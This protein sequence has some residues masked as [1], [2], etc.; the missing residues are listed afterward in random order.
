VL[1]RSRSA[2]DHG[3]ADADHAGLWLELARRNGMK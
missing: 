3:W 1:F 2:A